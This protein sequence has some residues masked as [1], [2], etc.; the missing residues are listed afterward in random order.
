MSA[1]ILN[2]DDNAPALYAKTRILRQAAFDVLEADSGREALEH[3]RTAKPRLVLLDVNLPDMSGLDVCRYIKDDPQ[4]A[5]TIVLQISATAAERADRVRG[6]EGGA[7]GYLTE[8]VEA[9]E[10]IAVIRA[11]LRLQTAEQALRES[12]ARYRTLIESLADG[13]YAAQR[14][15]FVFANEA[16]AAMLGYTAEEFVATPF[17]AVIA[18]E[19]LFIWTEQLRD[20]LSGAS[21]LL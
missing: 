17:A 3:V 12:E 13:A 14:D 19:S 16:L 18:P 6:L 2:V 9:A 1:L 4:T 7:D 20:C 5:N 8:P 21:D 15:R 10:L 11:Y